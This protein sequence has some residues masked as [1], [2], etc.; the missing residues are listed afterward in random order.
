[1]KLKPI[2]HHTVTMTIEYKATDEDDSQPG[3]VTPIR[4]KNPSISPYPGSYSQ[5]QM[6][7]MTADGRM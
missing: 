3:A 5:S 2:V 7:A 6:S 4:L 1:M